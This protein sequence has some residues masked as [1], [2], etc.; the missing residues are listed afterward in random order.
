MDCLS[1]TAARDPAA[2]LLTEA[3][4]SPRR[5]FYSLCGWVTHNA[6]CGVTTSADDRESAATAAW[7]SRGPFNASIHSQHT[8]TSGM[9]AVKRLLVYRR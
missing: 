5:C 7:S 3:A 2:N 4:C 6:A 1:I 9:A 8:Q